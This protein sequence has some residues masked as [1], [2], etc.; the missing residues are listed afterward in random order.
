[1]VFVLYRILSFDPE[2]LV[3]GDRRGIFEGLVLSIPLSKVDF[4]CYIVSV[5]VSTDKTMPKRTIQVRASISLMAAILMWS[6]VPLFLRSFIHEIDAWVANGS[7]YGVSALLWLG[8]FVVFVRRGHI[9]PRLLRLAIVPTIVNI[10]AQSFLAWT[11]YFMEP[12]MMMFLGR[13]SLLFSVFGSFIMFPDE[14][15]LIRSSYFW[16]GL[17]LLVAGFVGMNIAQGNLIASG[18]WE[19]LLIIIGHAFFIACYGIAMRH[20]MRG[21]NPLFSFSIICMYS[22]VLLIV[23]M[24]L[25][26]TPS[27]LLQMKWSRIVML[28]IS[29]LIGIAFSHVFFYDAIEHLGVSISNGC[30]LFAPFLTIV[31]SY[32]IYGETFRSIQWLFGFGLMCGASFLLI[33]QQHLG[34][35]K[36]AEEKE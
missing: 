30:L 17:V 11:I 29:A 18:N 22:S 6:A 9:T 31:S 12:G 7:R 14:L 15:A 34:E 26:G 8:P 24:F 21:V 19:G 2:A 33:A 23:I 13:L 27:D 3:T 32:F 10:I 4:G 36:R 25:F 28:I 5:V 35:R 16:A 1:M 20:Y